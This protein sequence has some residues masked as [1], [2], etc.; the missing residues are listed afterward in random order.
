MKFKFYL[1][2]LILFLSIR[3]GA[4]SCTRLT[5]SY[6]ATESRCVATGSI[7]VSVSGGSGN[8]NFKATGTIT[9]PT[10]SSNIITGLPPGI[11]SVLVKDLNTGCSKQLDNIQVTGSYSDPRF[12]LIKTDATCAG[13]DGTISVS[14]QQFGRSPFTYTIIAPSPSNI[15]ATS[16]S[17][18]FT[19]LTPGE[20]AIQLQDSCGG[21]QVRRITIENYNWWFDSLSVVK[22]GCDMVDVFIKLKDNKG[23]DNLTGTAFSGFKYGYVQNGDTIWYF[24]KSFTAL[25]ASQR[26]LTIIVKDNC[27]NVHSTVWTVPENTK[28]NLDAVIYSNRTCTTFTASV[29][30]QNLTNPNYCLYDNGGNLLTC[31]NTGVF[32]NLPYGSYCIEMTNQCYDTVIERCFVVSPNVPSVGSTV[33][34]SNQ[35][36]SSFTASVTGQQNLINPQYCLYD[37]TNVQIACNSTGV[38]TNL[39]YGPYC[40]KTYDGC[41]DTIITRCFTVRKAVPALTGYSLTGSTC[42]SFGIHIDGNNLINPKYCLYDDAGNVITCNYTGNF[43]NLVY[44]NYCVKA[45]SCGDTTNAICFT[46]SRPIPS[47]GPNAQITNKQCSGFDVSLTGPTNLTNPDY[48]LYDQ[49]DLLISCNSTGIFTNIPYGSYCIKVQNTCYDTIITRCFSQAKPV[50]AV[51]ATMQVLSSTCSTVSFSASGTNLTN[52]YYCLYDLQNNQIACN[53]TGIFNDI[54]FGYYCVTV[55]DGCVDTTMQVCQ[56]F[57]PTK[58]ISL[59]TSKSCNIGKTLVSVQFANSSTPFIVKIYHPNGS[60]LKTDTTNSNPY[61]VELSALSSGTKYK[62]VG[63]DNCG[64]KDSSGI[65]PDANI[66]TKAAAVKGKCPGSTWQNGLGDINTT[67]TSNF[68]GVTPQI[69]KKNGAAFTQGYSSVTGNVYTFVDLEPAQYIIEYTQA[70]CNGKLYDTVTVSPYMFPTQGQSA[71]YQCDNN[72]FSLGADVK[73]G[74]SPYNF[75]IIGSIPESPNITGPAQSSP[76]FSINNG[77]TYSLIRLRSIDAC[78]N[79]TLSDVSVLPL[80]NISVKASDSCFYKN[81]TLSVDTIANASYT[82][83]RK[84]TATDSTLLDSGLTYNLPFFQPE[85]IGQYICKVV[86]NNGCLVRLSSFTLSGNCYGAVLATPFQLQGKKTGNSNQIFWSTDEQKAVVKYIVERKNKEEQKYSPIAEMAVRIDGSYVFND[87]SFYPGFNQ[88][89]LKIVYVNKVGYS[90]VVELTTEQD[91]IAVYPNPVKSFYKVSLHSQNTTDYRI[92]LVSVSGQIQFRTEVKNSSSSTLTYNRD[93]HLV[94]G[95]YLLRITNERTGIT[96]IR[97]LVFE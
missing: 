36:C 24:N 40:I 94:T 76:V 3:A 46:G 43:D 49:N 31:D 39:P 62:I 65:I 84:T 48:C 32:P 80:Q 27:G 57:N 81:I 30:G 33:S 7:T 55:R 88:Y 2:P 87:N 89:R 38:F 20:Y 71:V 61:Q 97:K 74:V 54:P 93:S 96:E 22:N 68:Y 18:N 8:Y 44:A 25:I 9:T 21:I 4:Q 47:I 26:S 60:L 70:N 51:N 83:Y 69:I 79:A 37:S 50:P 19:G 5:V 56:T 10:T 91:E 92:E 16:A 35:N 78:G 90:N 66:V 77:T 63:I 29:T 45:I 6:S 64:N 42:S 73:G 14:N 59:T 11:Y 75:Q 53:S 13:N 86:V 58:G 12:Q 82:W 28:P 17:G 23:N 72:G 85:Q 1:L 15:G 67:I 34:L 95:I 52:P 41:V